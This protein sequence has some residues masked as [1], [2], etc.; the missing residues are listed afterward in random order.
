MP[1]TDDLTGQYANSGNLASRGSLHAKY[2][3]TDWF[4]W[5]RTRMPLP[6]H[7]RVLDVGCGPAWFWRAQ[8]PHLPDG[9]CLT[10]L[11]TSPGMVA[12]ALANLRTEERFQTVDGVASDLL[13]ASFANDSFDAVVLM[14][15]LYHVDDPYRMLSEVERILKPAGHVF[16]TSNEPD[17]MHELN[18]I[19][20]GVVGGTPIDRGA[21][22]FSL[23]DAEVSVGARFSD[24]RR[25]DLEDFYSVTD[26]EDI[27]RYLLSMPPG[28]QAEPPQRSDLRHQVEAS[29]S[30]NDGVFSIT[31][32][33]GLVVGTKPG[34]RNR[35]HASHPFKMP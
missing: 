19:S 2:A 26:P 7:A 32:R 22:R 15:V 27:I 10:L 14:H 4:D 1:G 6:E 24:V 12:E 13:E 5:L 25:Y 34:N 16:V 9:L 11:D 23:T 3:K 8:A 20:A 28:D 29:F 21:A 18:T 30:N 33:T 17:N 35:A 31:K